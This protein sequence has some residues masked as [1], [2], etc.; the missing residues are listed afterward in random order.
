VSYSSSFAFLNGSSDTTIALFVYEAT[1]EGANAVSLT[2]AELDF[3]RSDAGL[4][5]DHILRYGND[6]DPPRSIVSNGEGTMRVCLPIQVTDPSRV[7]AAVSTG[8]VPVQRPAILTDD[9][10]VVAIDY[11]LRPGSTTAAVSVEVAYANAFAYDAVM[12]YDIPALFVVVPGGARVNGEGFFPVPGEEESGHIVYQKENLAA[13]DRISFTVT[14]SLALPETME[15]PGMP[16]V[17]TRVIVG[18][19]RFAGIQW[20]GMGAILILLIGAMLIAGGNRE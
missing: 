13:G 12:L 16:R 15:A 20:Y 11:P 1:T 10:R 7:I 8:I 3:S 18:D 17:E 2:D 4:R 14:G 19:P 9:P 5:I 6:L